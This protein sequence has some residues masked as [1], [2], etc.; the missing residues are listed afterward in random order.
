MWNSQFLGYGF[1]V[2]KG[3]EVERREGA[4]ALKTMKERVREITSSNGGQSLGRVAGWL[5]EYLRGWK[6]YFRMAAT[7]GAQYKGQNTPGRVFW[8]PITKRPQGPDIQS[9]GHYTPSG[10]SN[11]PPPRPMA[12]KGSPC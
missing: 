2:A 6:D 7:P 1:W 10:R 5:K 9:C 11:L 3:M 12:A 4:K 8:P